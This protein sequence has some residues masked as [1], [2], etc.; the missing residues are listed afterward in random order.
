MKL[1]NT[2]LGLT[3]ATM[4]AAPAVAQDWPE[5]PINVVVP[6]QAGGSSDLVARSFTTAIDENDLL[7]QPISVINVGNHS[8]VGARRVL[9]AKPDGYEFLVH[10]T[11]LIGAEAAGIID[12]GHE[13]YEPVA[14]TGEICM[15]MLV[16]ED[17]G[18]DDLNDLLSAAAEEPDRLVFGVNIGGLNHMSGIMLENN[19]EAEFRF[20]QVGGS[21]DNFAALT[22]GQID[23][24]SVGAAGARSYTMTDDGE[25]SSESQV[26]TL[27]LLADEPDSRLP[28]VPTAREQ[29]VDVS[30]CFGNYW[31]APKDTPDEIVSAFADALE[32]AS[33]TD[34]LQT[35]YDDTLTTPIFLRGNEFSDYL[36]EQAEL[37][38]PIAEQAAAQ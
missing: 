19:S 20:A 17:S 31:L 26:K 34:R 21:A 33:E 10:E 7:P 25:I 28:G 9:D 2:L 1:S 13:D 12:F 29:G 23:V 4:T 24:A 30:F 36:D 11:G 18:Y 35:F 38:S 8:S 37:I 32:K 6:F 14:L 27:A 22:G 16:H 15:A 3:I 5:R